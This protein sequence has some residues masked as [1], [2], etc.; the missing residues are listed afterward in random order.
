MD[1]IEDGY[2][3]EV[4]HAYPPAG[5]K[6]HIPSKECWCHPEP[7]VIDPRIYIHKPDKSE[8]H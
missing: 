4:Y 1:E 6:E 7:D 3:T 8:V 5:R 2:Y